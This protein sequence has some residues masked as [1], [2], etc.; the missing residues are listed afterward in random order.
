VAEIAPK[1][2]GVAFA[3]PISLWTARPLS[4]IIVIVSPLIWVSKKIESAFASSE[5]TSVSEEEVLSIAAIGTEEGVLDSFEGSVIS[6]VIELDKVLVRD[7][8]TPRVVVFRLSQDAVISTLK[9]DVPQWSYTRVPVYEGTDSDN[10]KGY[11]IQRDIYRELLHG[12]EDKK[13][14]DI[15]RKLTIIPE[16]MRADQLLLKMFAEKEHICGVVDEHGSFVG[17]I[18]LEDI[19]EEIIGQEIVDE[20][21]AVSDM[22]SLARVFRMSKSRTQRESRKKTQTPLPERGAGIQSGTIKNSKS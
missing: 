7:V 15:S 3:K 9:Q 18:T 8:L 20:F 13:L 22:R 16:V 11:V 6:N 14:A 1:I 17:I 21:D 19:I 12:G 5:D 4:W 10:L 2:I